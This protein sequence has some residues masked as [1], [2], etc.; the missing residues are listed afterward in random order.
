MKNQCVT[1]KLPLITSF[2][3]NVHVW[4]HIINEILGENSEVTADNIRHI[5]IILQYLYHVAL[6]WIDFP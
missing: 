2:K 3:D 6:S 1:N 4:I 5:L